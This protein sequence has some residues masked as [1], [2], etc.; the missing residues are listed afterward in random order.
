MIHPF[1]ERG[2]TAM[3]GWTAASIFLSAALCAAGL[4]VSPP[5]FAQG[6][7][8]STGT[9]PAPAPVQS[10][11]LPPPGASP[12]TG[13]PPPPAST[14]PAPAPPASASPGAAGARPTLV[15]RAGDP[16]D[17]DEVTLPAKPVAILSGTST[18]DDGFTNLRNVFRKIEDELKRAGMAPAGR[19]LAIFVETDDTTFRYD[20]MVPI[21]R[22]PA[23]RPPTMPQDIRFGTTPEG[24]AL[25]FVHKGPYDDID[26]TYETITAYL[27]AKGIVVKDAFIEEYVNDAKDAQDPELE[28]NIFVQP[29]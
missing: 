29:R 14:Q 22:A 13:S 16:M 1:A 20:A 9:A 11:P 8:P 25:R 15:E 28:I 2:S 23:S 3:K 7:A 10:T 19:P 12:Q 6:A 17:V 18:W 21:D 24:R 27:D 26:S 5:L 4:V